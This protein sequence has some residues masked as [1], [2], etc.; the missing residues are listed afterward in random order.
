[1]MIVWLTI[2]VWML[3][4]TA[5]CLG[6]ASAA[7]RHLPQASTIPLKVIELPQPVAFEVAITARAAA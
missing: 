1:M 3:I 2:G 7:R 6:L 5:M 4:S